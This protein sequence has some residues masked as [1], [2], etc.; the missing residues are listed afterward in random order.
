[1]QARFW[2]MLTLLGS[3]VNKAGKFARGAK[4]LAIGS[5]VHAFG[6]TRPETV[7]VQA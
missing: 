4:P 3:R 1:M 2:M 5:E 7:A 6:T